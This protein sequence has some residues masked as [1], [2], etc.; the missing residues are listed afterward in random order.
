MKLFPSSMNMF[1]VFARPAIDAYNNAKAFYN[2]LAVK[3]S[4]IVIALEDATD[5]YSFHH[6]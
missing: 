1:T 4:I 2:N 6:H 3:T 5:K